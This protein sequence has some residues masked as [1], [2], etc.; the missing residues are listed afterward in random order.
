M[1]FNTILVKIDRPRRHI[2]FI[3]GDLAHPATGLEFDAQPLVQG[4]IRNIDTTLGAL[5]TP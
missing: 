3:N 2:V 1:V 4:P 5:G